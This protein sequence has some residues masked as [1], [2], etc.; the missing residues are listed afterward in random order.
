M[1]EYLHPAPKDQDEAQEKHRNMVNWVAAAFILL[2]FC[3]AFWVVKLFHDQEQLQRC[4]DSRRTTCFEF[5]DPPRDGIRL[6]AH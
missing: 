5:K 1:A 6:P 4:L 3:F 2:L